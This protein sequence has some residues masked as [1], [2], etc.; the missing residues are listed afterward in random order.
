MPDKADVLFAED[1]PVLREIY[2]KKFSIAGY[3]VRIAADGAE[4]IAMIEQKAP[5]AL[6][7]GINMPGV[8]G[9]D[10]L[11]KYP[12]ASRT[13]PVVLLTNLADEN[14]RQRG[15]ELGADNFFIKSEMTIKTLIEMVQDLLR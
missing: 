4:T 7:L 1:D 2:R 11:T 9:F 13:F 14:T 5:D 3:D 6:V 8:N 12:K 15:E 10:V